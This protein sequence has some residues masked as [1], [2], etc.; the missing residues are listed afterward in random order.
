MKQSMRFH[1]F[2]R[3]C[4]RAVLYLVKQGLVDSQQVFGTFGEKKEAVAVEVAH[5]VVPK[6]T[7][8]LNLPTVA[9][10]SPRINSLSLMGQGPHRTALTPRLLKISNLHLKHPTNSQ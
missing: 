1:C 4:I 9:L 6:Y 3:G 10:K 7:V 8:V 5:T 2:E